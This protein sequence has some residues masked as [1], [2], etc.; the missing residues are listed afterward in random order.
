MN[1]IIIIIIIIAQMWF[2]FGEEL[3]TNNNNISPHID[4][5]MPEDDPKSTPMPEL[6]AID[7]LMIEI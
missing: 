1:L 4:L 6:A 3:N 2:P 5:T 7:P